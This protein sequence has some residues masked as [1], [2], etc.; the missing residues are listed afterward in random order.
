M[1]FPSPLTYT[2]IGLSLSARL[3]YLLNPMNTAILPSEHLVSY[4]DALKN[5]IRGGHMFKKSYLLGLVLLTGVF[6]ARPYQRTTR[7]AAARPYSKCAKPCQEPC[8]ENEVYTTTM[9]KK[10]T[11]KANRAYADLVTS[12]A[13]Y[14][15]KANKVIKAATYA[16]QEQEVIGKEHGLT[17]H[18]AAIKARTTQE[19]LTEISAAA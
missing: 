2:G 18:A 14:E 17:A 16:A 3:N 15:T 13:A 4:K 8:E 9:S 11:E 6:S 7:M 1:L 12:L 19:A 5:P 10:A